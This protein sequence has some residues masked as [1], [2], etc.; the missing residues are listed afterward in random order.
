MSAPLIAD[1]IAFRLSW[2]ELDPAALT[3]LVRMARAE[4]L[5]GFGLARQPAQTGDV[6]SSVLGK[7]DQPAS[8]RLV[9]REDLVTSGIPLVPLVLVAYG[10]DGHFIPD[11]RDGEHCPAGTCLGTLEGPS[12][13]ILEAERVLL[14]FLQKL[15]G[16][17]TLTR[18]YVDALGDSPTRLLDTRKTTPGFRVLEK[19]AVACGGGFNH[20]I[21]LFDRVMLKDNH[22]AAEGAQ[23]G[24]ALTDLVRSTRA[25]WPGLL[26]ELEVDSIE[27]IPPALGAGVDVFL[28]D[29]FSMENLQQAVNIIGDKAATEASG[30]ITLDN[31]PTL[32]NM[33]LD[34][35]STG[36]TVHQSTWKDIGLD[37]N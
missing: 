8:A 7:T 10:E 15:S 9:A 21:G 14:N 30:G 34:F 27:Q 11:V 35:I 36:A 2:E 4:D 5:A 17:A 31:L 3:S 18:R 23:H 29:N 13:L 32:A 19:Y 12:R 6:S 33:G 25:K 20:R 22:L 26:I 16:V 28:L 24:P 1:R 37:W